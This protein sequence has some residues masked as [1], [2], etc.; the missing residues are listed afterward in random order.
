MS[1]APPDI[2]KLANRIAAIS[3]TGVFTPPLPQEKAAI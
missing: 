1:V 3:E 2:F